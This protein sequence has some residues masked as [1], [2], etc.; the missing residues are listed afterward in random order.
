MKTHGYKWQNATTW[1][2]IF[3]QS[4]VNGAP[5]QEEEH[6]FKWHWP[7]NTYL[8]RRLQHLRAYEPRRHS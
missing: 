5:Y 2:R 3:L 8:Q 6:G 4:K 7:K 1:Q